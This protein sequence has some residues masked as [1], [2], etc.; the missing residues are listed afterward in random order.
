MTLIVSN[1][2]K[3]LSE[4]YKFSEIMLSLGPPIED[5]RIIELEQQIGLVLPLDYKYIMQKHNY[6]SLGGTEVLGIGGGL[7]G[8]SINSLYVFEHEEV[9][10][11]M[12]KQFLPFSPDGYGNHYCLDLSK[13]ENDICPVIF[14]EHDCSYED[15]ND[16]E[17]CNTSF[18]EWIKEVMIDWNLEDTNY[19]GSD[20]EL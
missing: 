6:F 18:T 10:N 9:G 1:C 13:L 19:D 12:F 16:V 20:K 3:V 8:Y 4:L 5:N 17:V 2:D 11:P 14:W 7:N 15:K